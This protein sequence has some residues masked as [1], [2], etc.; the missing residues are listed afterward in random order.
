MLKH[1]GVEFQIC[2]NPDVKC[3]IIEQ[4]QRTIRERLNKYFIYKN[5][6]RFIDILRKFITGYNA[7]V[8]S[9]T[10]MATSKLTDTDILSIWKRLSTKRCHTRSVRPKFRVDQRVRISKEKMKFAK[11]SEQN[12][13]T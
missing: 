9:T 2:K 7:T 1:E 5:S 10:C 12:N 13:S 3:S 8:H 11:G 4:A 6:C